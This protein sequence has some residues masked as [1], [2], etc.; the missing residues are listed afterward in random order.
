MPPSPR[1]RGGATGFTASG[2]GSINDTG[3]QMPVGSTIAYTLTAT[4]SSSATGNLV[5]TA[6]VSPPAGTTDPN[7][8]NNSATDIRRINS[9]ADLGI[10]KSDGTATYVPGGNTTYTIVVSNNGPSA[11]AT[12][13]TVVDQLPAVLESATFTATSTGG[14]TGFTAS[15]SG[16]I[17]DTGIQMPVGSTITY[18][19]TATVSSSA[20]GNLVNTATVSPPAGTTDPNPGNNSATDIDAPS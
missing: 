16:S 3:I 7:P 17:N 8:G 5:N 2:S 12:G 9:Q 18:T 19:L 11:A 13:V 15:G 6:T 4:V 10:T 20:T 1:Q 14:A